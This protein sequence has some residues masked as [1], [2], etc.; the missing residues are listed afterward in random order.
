MF[1]LGTGGM[2]AGDYIY[3]DDIKIRKEVDIIRLSTRDVDLGDANIFDGQIIK[4]DQLTDVDSFIDV[5]VSGGIGAIT[6]YSF[7]I[8]R[9]TANARTSDFFN[10]FFPAYDG[11]QIVAREILFGFIWDDGSPDYSEVTWLMNGK[12]I[13]YSYEPRAINLIVL[14]STEIDTRE[15]PYYS[16]QKD[17]NN[18][19]S[20]FPS[21]PDE[22]YGNIIP[23][24]YG[25]HD[26]GTS[27]TGGAAV[28]GLVTY[29]PGII[30]DYGKNSILIASHKCESIAAV[31]TLS[32]YKFIEGLNSYMGLTSA[33][34]A[35]VNNNL[36]SYYSVTDTNTDIIG[37]M[38]IPLKA[39][40]SYSGV[41]TLFNVMDK[42]T[43]NFK[44]IDTTERLA[45]G[46]GGSASTTEVG[47]LSVTDG[48]SRVVWR[49]GSNDAGDR[50]WT[51]GI[52]NLTYGTPP[53]LDTV[54]TGT[55][56]ANNPSTVEIVHNFG[57][58]VVMKKDAIM[59]WTIEEVCNL[60]FY[61]INDD[62]DAGDYIEVYYA[63]LKLSN[64]KVS[65]IGKQ[66]TVKP[67]EIPSGI[68][69]AGTD[70]F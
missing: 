31:S 39:Q 2:G 14:Q 6:G 29:S 30:V 15:I 52:N 63:T 41:G 32:V 10:E 56:V 38:I 5:E 45:L 68:V 40:S 65:G 36:N 54:S 55:I 12:A 28:E 22:N 25:I 18:F 58:S 53:N 19:V 1:G 46:I 50:D 17:F 70:P 3:V 37:S 7:Q 44:Q 49:V 13:D 34:D 8:A 24:V 27:I 69:Y 66:Y 62:V 43:T 33:S 35:T 23:I 42:D 4:H 67:Y 11:G 16:V 57:A 9:H 64:I 61:I 59:P 60:E 20:Y 48:Q 51:L 47:W 21:A 26:V